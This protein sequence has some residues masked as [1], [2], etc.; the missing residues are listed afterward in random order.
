MNKKIIWLVWLVLVLGWNYS[1][2]EAIP[3]DD[4]FITIT[5]AVLVKYLE[6]VFG[7]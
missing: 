3:F 5:L 6:K 4:V 1:F 7:Q 2:P